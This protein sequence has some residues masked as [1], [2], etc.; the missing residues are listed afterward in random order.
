MGRL[1]FR[2]IFRSRESLAFV[3]IKE[4][5]SCPLLAEAS[6][7]NR[8]LAAAIALLFT[9]AD[10][11]YGGESMDVLRTGSRRGLCLMWSALW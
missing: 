10:G 8:E 5:Y 2:G 9:W 11:E 7:Y 3:E 4:I 1:L 6:S